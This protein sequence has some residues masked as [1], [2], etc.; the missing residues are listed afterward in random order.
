[1]FIHINSTQL[2]SPQLSTRWSDQRVG[3]EL[4]GARKGGIE[5]AE[6]VLALGED[7]LRVARAVPQ[8]ELRQ[9]AEGERDLV[10]LADDRARG[11]A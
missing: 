7:W 4:L 10:L 3:A 5:R 8:D 9:R 1:M 11:D 2:N 6:E